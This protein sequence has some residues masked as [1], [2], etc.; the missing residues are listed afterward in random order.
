VAR[1]KNQNLDCRSR[2]SRNAT[3][4]WRGVLGCVSPPIR[5]ALPVHALGGQNGSFF[6]LNPVA[7]TVVVAKAEFVQAALQVLLAAVLMHANHAALENAEEAFNRIG[8]HVG[9]PRLPVRRG[10]ASEQAAVRAIALD[11]VT[12]MRSVP[13]KA[14]GG[15]TGEQRGIGGPS[16]SP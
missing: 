4:N 3:V 5:Q 1:E 8:G 14:C 6:V 2:Q 16:I 15:H 10:R 12:H 7:N 11:V 13:A 9:G